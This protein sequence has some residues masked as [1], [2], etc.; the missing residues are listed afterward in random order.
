MPEQ[1]SEFERWMRYDFL[2]KQ[3]DGAMWRGKPA[4]E[5]AMHYLQALQDR[6]EHMFRDGYEDGI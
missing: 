1:L 4:G 2:P 5:A 3:S 6:I